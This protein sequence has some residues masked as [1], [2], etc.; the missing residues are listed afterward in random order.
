MS[1]RQDMAGIVERLEAASGPSNELN[2]LILK[3]SKPEFA[4]TTVVS[5]WLVG[6]NH[7]VPTLAPPFTSSIDA[8]LSLVPEGWIAGELQWWKCEAA[9]RMAWCQL[10]S[11]AGDGL[12]ATVEGRG[13]TPAIAIVI[14]A[15]R[16]RAHKE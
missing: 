3:E 13:A 8:A 11:D 15:L 4:D 14:A 16:A 5:G 9:P 1:E 7:A 12:L 6:G 10:E 2:G